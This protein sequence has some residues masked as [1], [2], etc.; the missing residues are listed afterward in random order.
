M[1]PQM[2][3]INGSFEICQ[4]RMFVKQ[5][6]THGWSTYLLSKKIFMLKQKSSNLCVIWVKNW[7]IVYP[8]Y[9]RN[10]SQWNA[11]WQDNQPHGYSRL[12][13]FL[14]SM[15]RMRDCRQNHHDCRQDIPRL[16]WND[17]LTTP[18]VSEHYKYMFLVA[19]DMYEM[20]VL[21]RGKHTTQRSTVGI[22]SEVRVYRTPATNMS[23]AGVLRLCS[24]LD[25][26]RLKC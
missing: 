15:K 14:H 5:H 7:V 23:W 3:Y 1:L 4:Q 25:K 16:L 12:I 13:L 20:L 21:Y 10:C 18:Y 24:F 9:I 11:M 22:W 19:R 2:L 8:H 6:W 17:L 26:R